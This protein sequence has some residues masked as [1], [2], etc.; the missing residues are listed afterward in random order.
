MKGHDAISEYSSEHIKSIRHIHI[1]F[2]QVFCTYIYVH[3][4]Y[5]FHI[6]KCTASRFLIGEKTDE[7]I[8]SFLK[9]PNVKDFI[10]F[11]CKKKNDPSSEMWKCG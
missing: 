6:R 1:L 8:K 7:I 3:E 11:S 5:W 9:H 4:I 2:S 10:F